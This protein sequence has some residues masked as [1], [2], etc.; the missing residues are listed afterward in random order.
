MDSYWGWGP[1]WYTVCSALNLSNNDSDNG[2][3]LKVWGCKNK[4]KTM[5]AIS[6]K[7]QL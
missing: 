6:Y 7:L 1:S 2:A 4:I 3:Q 5:V